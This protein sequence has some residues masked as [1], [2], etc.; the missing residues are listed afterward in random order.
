MHA[1]NFV[2]RL[3][4]FLCSGCSPRDLNELL[5]GFDGTLLER[6]RAFCTEYCSHLASSNDA[7]F[8][9]VRLQKL[10]KYLDGLKQQ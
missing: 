5:N 7:G 10:Q 8:D 9:P 3:S 1:Y 6:A 4:E 2:C